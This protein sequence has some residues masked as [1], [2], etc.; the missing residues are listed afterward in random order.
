MSDREF[1]SALCSYLPFGPVRIK[2]LLSYFG[3]ARKVW[4]A[5][6]NS[7]TA[8]G[9]SAKIVESFGVYR[10]KFDFTTYLNRLNKLSIRFTILGEADYPE[11]LR[12]ISNPPYVLYYLGV[13]KK[14]VPGR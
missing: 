6:A 8:V 7:L 2:L 4:E 3:S 10:K 14:S 5:D 9:L 12:E 1:A 11:N 13:L